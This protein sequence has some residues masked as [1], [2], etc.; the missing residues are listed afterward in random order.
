MTI[1][2]LWAA[3]QE[4]EGA[5]WMIVAIDE[6]SWEGDPD[7]AEAKFLLARD[8][9]KRNNWHTREIHLRVNMKMV[10]KAFL[11]DEIEATTQ[12]VV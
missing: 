4:D 10:E 7:A 11:P 8:E 9:A 12:A 1:Y 5:F 6:F 2:T 3:L